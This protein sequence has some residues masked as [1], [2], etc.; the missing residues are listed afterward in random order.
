MF[1][2]Q[3]KNAIPAPIETKEQIKKKK[4]Q[5]EAIGKINKILDDN[6]LDIKIEQRI[7]FVAVKPEVRS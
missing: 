5:M 1:N 2:V 3:K 4:Q 6:D 7:S